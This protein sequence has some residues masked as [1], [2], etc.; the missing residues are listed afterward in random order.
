VPPGLLI[1]EDRQVQLTP[2]F[3]EHKKEIEKILD[4]FR[5]SEGKPSHGIAVLN[6]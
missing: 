5:V 1:G 3:S 2:T 4:S 6:K